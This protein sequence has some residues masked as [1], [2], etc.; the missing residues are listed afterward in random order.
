M[1]KSHLPGNRFSFLPQFVA[2]Q[3]QSSITQIS[4]NLD[5]SFFQLRLF[6]EHLKEKCKNTVE[7]AI[8]DEIKKKL[9]GGHIAA[10]IKFPV[11]SLSFPC[12]R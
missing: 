9:Q 6:E 7:S 10:K 11:F 4:I 1:T 8:S 2:H 12:V 3:F 5:Y